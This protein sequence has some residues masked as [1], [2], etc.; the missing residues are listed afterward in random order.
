MKAR[1]RPHEGIDLWQWRNDNGGIMTLKP[2]VRVGCA[3]TGKIVNISPDFIRLLKKPSW[4]FQLP[5]G[6]NKFRPTSRFH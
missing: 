5:V 1:N 3:M 6:Q 4:L 2:A